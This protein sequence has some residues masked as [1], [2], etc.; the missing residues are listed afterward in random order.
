M[1]GSGWTL[2]AAGRTAVTTKPADSMKPRAVPRKRSLKLITDSRMAATTGLA[3]LSR[4]AAKRESD[5]ALVYSPSS[6][7]RSG[8]IAWKAGVKA[9]E[10]M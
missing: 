4:S 8:I 3:T 1:N 2:D 10:A 6:S 7:R 5:S 9:A